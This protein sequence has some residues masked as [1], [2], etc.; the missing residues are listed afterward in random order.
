MRTI[1]WKM[2]GDAELVDDV[3]QDAYLKAHRSI[4][5]FRGDA[6]FQTWLHRIVVNAGVDHLRRLS[7]R[8]EVSLDHQPELALPCEDDRVSDGERV[9]QALLALPA[10]QRVAILLVDCEGYSY[11]EAAEILGITQGA[12]GSRLF[13]ARSTLQTMG[14]LS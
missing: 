4:G 6:Q 14:E 1:A 5:Q 12:V 9:R 8:R 3:L 13:R 10:D 7:T 11:D 2:L